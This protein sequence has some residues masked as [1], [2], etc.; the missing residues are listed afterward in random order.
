VAKNKFTHKKVDNF[1]IF[2][3]LRK[4]EKNSPTGAVHSSTLSVSDLSASPPSIPHPI[5]AI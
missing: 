1:W 3:S 4:K 5:S 2:G